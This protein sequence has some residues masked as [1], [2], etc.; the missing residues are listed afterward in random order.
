MDQLAEVRN[1]QLVERLSYLFTLPRESRYAFYNGFD[2]LQPIWGNVG[3]VIS[4]LAALTRGLRDHP[5]T[6]A[7][8]QLLLRLSGAPLKLHG[9]ADLMAFEFDREEL[10]VAV[11]ISDAPLSVPDLLELGHDPDV[12]RRVVYS[13]IIT[14]CVAPVASA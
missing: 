2:L 1:E 4:P 7:M 5:E 6:E 3:G 8:D 14:H 9:E 13:L 12:V 10:A 11:A